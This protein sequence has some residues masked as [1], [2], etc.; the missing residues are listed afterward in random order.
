MAYTIELISAELYFLT[1]VSVHPK[2]EPTLKG[3]LLLESTTCQSPLSFFGAEQTSGD[4]CLCELNPPN[5]RKAPNL[6]KSW[7]TWRLR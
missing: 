1:R 4:T 3:P 6:N 2:P 7:W 5:P